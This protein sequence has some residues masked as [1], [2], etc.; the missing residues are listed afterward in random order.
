MMM[1]LSCAFWCIAVMKQ[2]SNCG[3]FWPV[4][5]SLRASI[6]AQARARFGQRLDLGAIAGFGG[7]FPF[8]D[9]AKIGDFFQSV[10]DGLFFGVVNFLAAGVVGA[11]LHVTGAQR[12][13]VLLEER[14][15]LEEELLLKI[16]GAGGNHDALAGKN[17]GN[18]IRQRLAGAGAGFDDQVL[19]FGERGFARLPPLPVGRR[20]IRSSGCHSESSPLRPKNWRTVSGLVAEDTYWMILAGAC[21][22]PRSI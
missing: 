10:E 8:A 22:W 12:A 4:H 5:S 20:G 6:L 7:L 11:A 9:D 14:N 19:L 16:L 17:R 21:G 18:Q 15:V 13:Q 1:S 2:R 3:H